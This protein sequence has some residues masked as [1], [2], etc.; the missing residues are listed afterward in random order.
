MGSH[1][2][3]AAP[4]SNN[5]KGNWYLKLEF[6]LAI[7]PNKETSRGNMHQSYYSWSKH[8]SNL[9]LLLV[10]TFFFLSLWVK[11]SRIHKHFSF[12]EEVITFYLFYLIECWLRLITYCMFP[13]EL[14][15]SLSIF[16]I[17]LIIQNHKGYCKQFSFLFYMW[18]PAV[19]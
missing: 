11:K 5:S 9:F 16:Q 13:I 17:K 2:Y 6:L 12:S 14:L 3:Q 19:Q 7:S 10:A 18:F 4:I 8:C 15:P 1:S